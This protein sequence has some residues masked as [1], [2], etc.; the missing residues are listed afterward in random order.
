MRNLGSVAS[1]LRKVPSKLLPL[2]GFAVG[3]VLDS[4]ATACAAG[5]VD[6]YTNT[7]PQNS[8]K[9]RYEVNST[10]VNFIDL[11]E[12]VQLEKL[13]NPAVCDFTLVSMTSF[14]LNRKKLVPVARGKVSSTCRSPKRQDVN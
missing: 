4:Q 11:P 5:D 13:K 1:A 3:A 10:V 12:S 8:C 2:A 9:P 7:D 14:W 6:K